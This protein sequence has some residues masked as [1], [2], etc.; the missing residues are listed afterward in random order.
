MG[1]YLCTSSNLVV[2]FS[3]PSVAGTDCCTLLCYDIILN[4]FPTTVIF[5]FP[6]LRYIPQTLIDST[7]G[8]TA[9]QLNCVFV[10]ICVCICAFVYVFVSVFVSVAIAVLL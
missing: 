6:F 9:A 7:A 5:V 2:Q 4:M 10:C 8:S 1:L 3:K